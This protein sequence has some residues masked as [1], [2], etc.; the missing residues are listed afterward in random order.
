MPCT[1]VSVTDYTTT[2]T[3]YASYKVC[4]P[5]DGGDDTYRPPDGPGSESGFSGGGGGGGPIYPPGF[6]LDP[7]GSGVV[8]LPDTA[9]PED[10]VVDLNPGWNGGAHS[11]ESVPADWVGVVSFDVPDIQGARQGGVA[12]GFAPVSSLPVAGR[13]GYGHLLYGLVFTVDMVRVIHAGAVV[14]EGPYADIRAA[15]DGGS[16]DLVSALLYGAAIKW[17]V[18]GQTL[19]SGPFMMPEPYALDATLYLAFDAVDN[20]VFTEGEWGDIETDSLNGV[21][22]GFAMTGD[23]SAAPSL[24]ITLPAFAA[25]LSENVVWNLFG[26]L[27]GFQMEAGGGEG[28]SGTIGPF[29]MVAAQAASYTT[30]TGAIGPFGMTG[31]MEEPDE[32]VKYCALAATLPRFA[33]AAAGPISATINAALQP[34]TMRASSEASYSELSAQIGGLRF[35]GYGGELTPLVQIM[36]TIA[37]HAP[38]HL[39]T[40]IAMA[41]IERV[42]GTTTAAAY[43]TITADGTEEITAQD[44]ASYTAALFNSVAEQLGVGER[45]VALTY[46]LNGDTLVDDGEAWVVNAE[47]G[48]STRYENYGFNSFAT[49]RGVQLG[50]RSD[51]VFVLSGADDAGAPIASGISLGTHDFGTQALKR[52]DYVYAGVSSTGALFIR[53]GDGVNAYSYKARRSDDHLRVQRFDVGRGIRTNYFTFDLTSDADAFELDSVTF[54]VLPTNRRI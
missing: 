9:A 18:N 15:R 10:P 26:N 27:S 8:V 7:S 28:I 25:Q 11:I 14:L 47:S 35:A 44:A 5:D 46:R 12:A 54:H 6:D 51:G 16:T 41:F 39:S 29:Q 23:A 13:S 42:D 49:V 19:F 48:A 50:A 43:A 33:M 34:M 37:Y 2:P 53:V 21:L 40:F 20:P 30:I 4:L 38:L 45:L 3:S 24:A 52:L 31:G 36:E 17:V 32:T 1:L 22:P